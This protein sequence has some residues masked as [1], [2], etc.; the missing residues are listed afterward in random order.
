MKIKTITINNKKKCFDIQ[1]SSKALLS[2]PFSK[3]RLIPTAYNKISSAWVDKELGNQWVTYQFSSG[4]EDSVPLD[5][6]LEYNRDPDYMRRLSLHKLTVLALQFIEKS[7]LAKREIAR[8]LAT[9][10]TQLYRLLD[11]A[12]YRKT[13]DQMIRLLT[14]LGYEVDIVPREIVSPIRNAKKAS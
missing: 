1:T 7:H 8:K 13:I 5:A 14:A 2:L 11:T 6:F 4:E 12:N 10:P 3:L 9:S